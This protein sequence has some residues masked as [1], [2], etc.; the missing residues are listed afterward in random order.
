MLLGLVASIVA[1]TVWVTAVSLSISLIILIIG[2]PIVLLSFALFRAMFGENY[3]TVFRVAPGDGDADAVG[4]DALAYP[5]APPFR[6]AQDVAHPEGVVELYTG[7]PLVQALL[8]L[9]AA[10][11]LVPGRPAS[12][13]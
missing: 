9:L 5:G 6:F 2:L 12:A 1:F 3:Y 7:A 13:P 11:I 8:G 10:V 4:Q